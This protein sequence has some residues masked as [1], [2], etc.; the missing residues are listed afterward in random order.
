M[1]CFPYGK[2]EQLNR[3]H[4]LADVNLSDGSW[5][6]CEQEKK[7]SK[8]LARN[9]IEAHVIRRPFSGFCIAKERHFIEMQ[10]ILNL[11]D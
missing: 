1:F 10:K 11:R 3:T 9:R 2:G 6:Q 4:T 8:K 5:K 7:R